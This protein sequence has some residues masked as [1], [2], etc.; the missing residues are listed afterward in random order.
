MKLEIIELSKL[1]SIKE[2]IDE[3]IWMFF[4]RRSAVAIHTIVGAAHQSLHDITNRK[5]SMLKNENAASNSGKGNEWFTRLNK[6]FNFLKH[7]Q[8]DSE[9]YLSFGPLMHTFYLYDCVNMYIIH[10]GETHFNHQLFRGWFNIANRYLAAPEH[11]AL[12]DLVAIDEM[13]PENYEYFALQL[14]ENS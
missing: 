13:N 7:G 14:R 6:E 8:K 12:L 3:A 1:Q 2:Q 5:I 9:E 11:K 4:N 10:T